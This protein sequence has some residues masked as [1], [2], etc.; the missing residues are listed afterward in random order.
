[1]PGLA[2][3]AR[4]G[5]GHPSWAPLE[6]EELAGLALLRGSPRLLWLRPA[7]GSATPLTANQT[8]FKGSPTLWPGKGPSAAHHGPA[9]PGTPLEQCQTLSA[10]H[11]LP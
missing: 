11:T 10:I 6:E 4:P 7:A 9:F 3:G 5:R 1:M 2:E 8:H